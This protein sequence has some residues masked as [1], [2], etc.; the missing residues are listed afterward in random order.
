MH[1]RG[2]FPVLPTLRCYGFPSFHYIHL[3]PFPQALLELVTGTVEGALGRGS[4]ISI[5]V[6]SCHPDP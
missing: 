3:C 1:V 4:L 5:P 2:T 6:T